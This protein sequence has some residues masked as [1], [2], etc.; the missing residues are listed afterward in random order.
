MIKFTIILLSSI[1]SL[2]AS[3][4]LFD[5]FD[6]SDKEI[7]EIPTAAAI[8]AELAF[9]DTSEPDFD[10]PTSPQLHYETIVKDTEYLK[11]HYEE[12]VL[13]LKSFDSLEHN[14]RGY[15][16]RKVVSD[17][18]NYFKDK[19]LLNQTDLMEIRNNLNEVINK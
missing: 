9:Q 8:N 3:A 7:K 1:V 18:K 13:I 5:Y 11:S 14:L 15:E 12:L 10:L 19:Y 4:G 16:E 6:F 2:T 17:L